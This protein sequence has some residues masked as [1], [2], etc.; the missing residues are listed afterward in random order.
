MLEAKVF[1]MIREVM[2][3]PMKLRECMDFFRD[4]ARPD[5]SHIQGQLT[6][7][8]NRAMATEGRKEAPDRFVRGGR[9]VRGG[10]FDDNGADLPRPT[11]VAPSIAESIV[12]KIEI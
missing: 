2:L 1:E 10:L 11:S 8:Q 12:C 5:R 3:D 6:R 7:I 4:A 9:A